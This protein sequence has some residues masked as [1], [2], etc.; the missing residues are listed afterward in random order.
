MNRLPIYASA[1][2]L[3]A[4]LVAV[5]PAISKQPY[6]P[7][8]VEAEI[9]APGDGLG[10]PS[11]RAFVSK[12]VRAPFR[13]N[14]VGLNWAGD[15]E[16]AIAVRVRAEGEPWGDWTAVPATSDGGPDPRGSEAAVGR[17]VSQ[18]V[19]AGEADFF[20]YRLSRRPPDLDLHFINTTGT[21]TEADR[22]ETALRDALD[23][24][25]VALADI[26]APFAE[27]GDTPPEMIRRERW[28]GDDCRPRRRPDY[29]RVKVAFIH[30]TVNANS[31]SRA[32]APG[33]VLGI[34][35]YHRNSN[36]WDD[37]GYNFLVDKYGR[38]YEGRAGGIGRAVVGAQV[39]GF[40]AQSTGI[41]NLGTYSSRRQTRAGMRAMARLIRWK[42]PHHGQPTSG[43][44]TLI[45]AGG[46]VNPYPEG[47]R[48]RLRRIP[49][50]RDAGSTSCPGDRLYRQ[51]HRLRRIVA[52]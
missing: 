14:I 31:Y 17:S 39:Q 24:V 18:P 45:S 16:P 13:F 46:D 51:L 33:M 34:C 23:S 29:G 25:A 40:N 8:P 19:W 41:A 21:A 6:R 42:L 15:R 2:A 27:A 12:P 5:A 47:M 22:I 37:I 4:V 32:E 10:A 36:G 7:S 44:T 49:G 11:A 9:D 50:H 1:V 35:R 52:G 20:Q 48:V 43:R 3:V 38:I 28:A 26:T 30:H